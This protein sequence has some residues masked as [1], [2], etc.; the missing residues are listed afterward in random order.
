MI[1][2]DLIAI[3]FVIELISKMFKDF[4]YT[5]L[6]REMNRNLPDELNFTK[7]AENAEL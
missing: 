4:T 1:N 2:S 5:W 6:A 3:T 7:E